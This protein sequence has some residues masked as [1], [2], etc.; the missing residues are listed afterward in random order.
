MQPNLLAHNEDIRY[1]T[2]KHW[3]VFIKA[4]IFFGLALLVLA[5]KET[6]LNATKFTPPAD[7]ERF[8]TPLVKY[9]VLGVCFGLAVVFGYLGLSRML[10]FF[11]AKVFIT[12]KRVIS[13]DVLSGSILSL[14]LGGVESVLACTGPL[15]SV[16]GYGKVVVSMASGQKVS[17][18]NMRRPHE[19][20]RE[21][22]AAK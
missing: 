18:P 10:S 22:F 11:S 4:A 19:L 9:T 16:L 8:V 13:R 12:A 2:S 3:A 1:Q 17:L 20:E 14:D 15:G 5:N 7:L 21:I 6:L